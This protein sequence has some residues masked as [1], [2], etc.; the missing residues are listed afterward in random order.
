MTNDYDDL[1]ALLTRAVSVAFHLDTNSV[2]ADVQVAVVETPTADALAVLDDLDEARRERD[3]AQAEVERLRAACSMTT[4][5]CPRCGGD[6]RRI[7]GS[8]ATWHGGI[9]G[10]MLTVDVCDGCW[11]TGDAVRKGVDLRKMTRAWEHLRKEV[12][13]AAEILDID[14]D[15]FVLCGPA[16]AVRKAREAR[17]ILRKALGGEGS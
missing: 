14:V 1:R 7:Y 16:F 15:T 6:G 10:Q 3:D 13:R 2:A 4:N 8:T 9:G 5:P 11:G 17:E 12:E